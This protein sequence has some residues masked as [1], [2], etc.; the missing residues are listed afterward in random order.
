[1]KIFKTRCRVL[2]YIA[3]NGVERFY[4]Q[5][6][7][8]FIWWNL[9]NE[10]SH[11]AVFNTLNEAN[12]FLAK[13]YITE[14]KEKEKKNNGQIVTRKTHSFNEVFHKLKER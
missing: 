3:K 2:Q 7:S 8:C 4:P 12:D 6:R 10:Y 5:K 1:M 13:L 9:D 11:S 14:R